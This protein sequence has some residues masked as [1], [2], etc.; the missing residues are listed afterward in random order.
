MRLL[1]VA[2]LVAAL[3]LL[4]VGAGWLVAQAQQPSD[5]PEGPPPKVTWEPP[6]ITGTV[7][8]TTTFTAT[9][10]VSPTVDDLECVVR[11]KKFDADG[12]T[13][14]ITGT[15]TVT[16][17]LTV[18]PTDDQHGASFNFQVFLRADG[19]ERV[20]APPLRV[21]LFTERQPG[22]EHIAPGGPENVPPGKNEDHGGRGQSGED[23]GR[24]G[25]RR[26][27]R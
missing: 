14:T 7:T 18:T 15:N 1:R 23:H 17:T 2:P 13:C 22:E 24:S 4:G 11:P 26:G 10:T 6:L 3:L 21:R 27:G 9:A 20:L 12:V 16:V 5:E 19:D 8:T 25:G